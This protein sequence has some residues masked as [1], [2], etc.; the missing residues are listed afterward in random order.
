MS[1]FLVD[2]AV[3]LVESE[4]LQQEYRKGVLSAR[5]Y[6]KVL[7]LA[8]T[9]ADLAGREEISCKDLTEALFFRNGGPSGEEGGEGI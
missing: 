7:R 5:G 8:R 1:A 3:G 6:V 9:V 4:L 2:S